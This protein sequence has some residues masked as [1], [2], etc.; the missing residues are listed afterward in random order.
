[1]TIRAHCEP[2]LPFLL[3]DFCWHCQL[4]ESRLAVWVHT[5]NNG[6]CPGFLIR[7]HVQVGLRRDD[8]E[9]PDV[10]QWLVAP[11]RGS[12]S[13]TVSAQDRADW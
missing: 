3:Y 9:R 6:Y 11:T 13:C 5:L 2:F 10:A 12:H 4:A 1:M 8:G 7:R